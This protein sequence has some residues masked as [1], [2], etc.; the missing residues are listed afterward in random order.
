MNR[1]R[2]AASMIPVAAGLAVAVDEDDPDTV[3]EILTTLSTQQLYALAVVLAAH[4]DPE[5]PL[6]RA[7]VAGATKRAAHKAAVL[8]QVD[9]TAIFGPSRYQDV[10]TARV[11]TYYAAHLL[12]DTYSQI[13]RVLNRDHSSVMSGVN[14]V[15]A[16][17]QLREVARAIARDLGWAPDTQEVGA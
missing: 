14:R 7:D 8:Y 5:K 11:V 10:T 13:G 9:V 12:G 17:Q 1:D 2:L 16:D 15:G 6:V 3:E 4:I